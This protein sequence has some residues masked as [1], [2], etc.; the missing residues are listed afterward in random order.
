MGKPKKA[1]RTCMVREYTRYSRSQSTKYVKVYKKRRHV[2]H[3][4]S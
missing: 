1:L 4:V 2:R 3:K